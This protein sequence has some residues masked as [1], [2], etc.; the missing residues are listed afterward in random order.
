MKRGDTAVLV[1][2]M[3]IGAVDKEELLVLSLR[4]GH[5]F[6]SKSMRSVTGSP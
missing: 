4:T 6:R 2:D 1:I 3:Q 5:Q